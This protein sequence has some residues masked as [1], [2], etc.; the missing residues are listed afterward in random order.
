MSWD[1]CEF[2]WLRFLSVLLA[3]FALA[4]VGSACGSGD[5][6]G[7]SGGA[8]ASNANGGGSVVAAGAEKEIRALY[9]EYAASLKDGSYE[10]VC[11][12]YSEAFKKKYTRETAKLFDKPA[13]GRWDCAT[14]SRV[15]F[16]GSSNITA[17]PL[18]EVRMVDS[19]SAIGVTQG[20]TSSKNAFVKVS[21]EWKIDGPIR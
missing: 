6:D 19:T 11:S 1:R 3:V 8:A 18:T 9:E 13:S 17:S 14:A 2:G 21:G 20:K 12:T 5:D 10:E 7:D 15:S 4:L 16:K